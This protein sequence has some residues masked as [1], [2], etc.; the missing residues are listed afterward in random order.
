MFR[1]LRI[2][3]ASYFCK[4]LASTHGGR[5]AP[6]RAAQAKFETLGLSVAVQRIAFF[7]IFFSI[8]PIKSQQN[9]HFFLLIKPDTFDPVR[10]RVGTP[11]FL[12]ISFLQRSS[13]KKHSPP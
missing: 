11:P 6:P 7:S 5:F 2:L 3:A 1:K 4:S 12:A 13:R 10:I 8:L 9:G